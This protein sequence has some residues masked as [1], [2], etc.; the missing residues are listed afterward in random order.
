MIH[1]GLW[2]KLAK[3]RPESVCERSLAERDEAT[4]GFLLPVLNRRYLIEPA[5]RTVTLE[6]APAAA[7]P[8]AFHVQLLAVNY[9]IGARGVP[10]AGELTTAGQLPGG[11]TFFRG[12]HGMPTEKLTDR[13]GSDADGFLAAGRAL[14][15][16]P[17]EHGDAAVELPLLPKIPI[18][19]V[20]WLADP[21][22]FARVSYLFDR[23]ATVHLQLDALLAAAQLAQK[24]LVGAALRHSVSQ[25]SRQVRPV[26]GPSDPTIR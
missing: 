6:G 4:G 10:L 25:E 2:D 20:L 17:C 12:S 1:S 18:T 9:L 8:P 24:E 22:F 5:A 23:S 11:E 13:F 15:G 19:V 7:E 3:L 26:T 14:G 16:R 21:E